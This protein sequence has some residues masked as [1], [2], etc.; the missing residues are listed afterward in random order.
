MDQL[1]MISFSAIAA[2]WQQ[3]LSGNEIESFN[4]SALVNVALQ[5]GGL[6]LPTSS[7]DAM[8]DGKINLQPLESA[9]NEGLG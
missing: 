9:M 3:S 5:A 6:V 2:L 4:A 7:H 8:K 1:P